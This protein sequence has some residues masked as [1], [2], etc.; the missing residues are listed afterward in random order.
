M[1]NEM[2]ITLHI[3]VDSSCVEGDNSWEAGMHTHLFV[4]RVISRC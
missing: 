3:A 2:H 1:Q 4:A